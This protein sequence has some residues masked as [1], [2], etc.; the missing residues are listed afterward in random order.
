MTLRPSP[1]AMSR[2]RNGRRPY[3]VLIDCNSHVFNRTRLA[4]SSHKT[5][6]KGAHLRYGP[7]TTPMGSHENVRLFPITGSCS[8][9]IWKPPWNSNFTS[10]AHQAGR[11]RMSGPNRMSQ[12]RQK[13]KAP[14]PE[15]SAQHIWL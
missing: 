15:S 1:L 9:A 11:Y 3:K 5:P 4:R 2:T 7:V 14:V 8:R 6:Y 13:V 12:Q 10:V